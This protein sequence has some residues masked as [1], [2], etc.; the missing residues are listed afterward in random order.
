MAHTKVQR[1][2]RT[3]RRTPTPAKIAFA[4]ENVWEWISKSGSQMGSFTEA[5][6]AN[7]L[8]KSF[9]KGV[10]DSHGWVN[11]FCEPIVVCLEP[12]DLLM[13]EGENGAGRGTVLELGGK[14]MGKEIVLGTFFVGLQGIVENKLEIGG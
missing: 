6:Q 3:E 1:R 2:I 9:G 8:S 4:G 11:P 5:Y 10:Q 13:N 7:T 14:W 12:L